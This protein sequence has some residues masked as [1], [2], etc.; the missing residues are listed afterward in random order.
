MA[1]GTDKKPR[2]PGVFRFLNDLRNPRIPRDLP[3]ISRRSMS[4]LALAGRY[5]SGEGSLKI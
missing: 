5:V 4:N 1:G 3:F 2:D